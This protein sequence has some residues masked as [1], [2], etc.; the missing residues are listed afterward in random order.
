LRHDIVPDFARRLAERLG[1]PYAETLTKTHPTP[2]QKTMENGPQQERN[3]ID[4][5]V[6]DAAAVR[7]GAVIL[8]DDM[9]DSRW[10]LTA[11]GVALRKAGSGPVYPIAL[12]DTSV[13]GG[14]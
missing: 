13:G 8:V 12:A 7:P 9:V 4:T 11:C 2:Q 14:P 6:G 5:F 1:L 3:V 10:T